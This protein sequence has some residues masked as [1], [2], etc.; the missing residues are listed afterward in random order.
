MQIVIT[1][2]DVSTGATGAT[3]VAHKFSD[4][5]TL[6]QLRG[7]DSA[8]HWHGRTYIFPVVTSLTH[9]TRYVSRVVKYNKKSFHHL[10]T[11]FIST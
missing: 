8:H 11:F 3:R 2:R 5:L 7:A 1:L 6:F 9:N 4:T 10:T